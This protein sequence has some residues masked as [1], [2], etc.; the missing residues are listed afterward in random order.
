MGQSKRI[1]FIGL[2]NMGG[3]LANRFAQFTPLVVFDLDQS[4]I[5]SIVA[6]GAKA[7][8][9]VADL[10]EKT[11]LVFV[12]LPNSE[13]VKE[14]VLGDGGL[15]SKLSKG[16]LI[17]DMTTGDPNMTREI[18]K[19]LVQMKIEFI[20]APVSGGPRGAQEGNIAIM[21]GGSLEQYNRISPILRKISTNVIYSGELGAGHAIKAGNN[22]LNLICRLATFEVVSLLVKDGVDP[23]IA[24]NTIQ[25][26]SG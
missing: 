14:V 1:G 24:V 22:L 8:D 12:S 13:T 15:S 3:P 9:S 21:V 17:V 18:A 19:T 11:D 6:L 2:G 16:S 23:E 4:R 20:D 7:A 25:K 10:A 5:N 26:S